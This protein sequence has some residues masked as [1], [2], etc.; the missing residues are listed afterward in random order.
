MA[1]M[2]LRLQIKVNMINDDHGITDC[3]DDSNGDHG[4]VVGMR[5]PRAA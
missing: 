5:G 2:L 4:G 1:V 3:Y